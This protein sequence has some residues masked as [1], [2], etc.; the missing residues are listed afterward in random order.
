MPCSV[1]C[2]S[3]SASRRLAQG[4]SSAIIGRHVSTPNDL[5]R[6]DANLVG[7]DI[8]GGTAQLHQQL[9]FR[10]VSGLARA[11]TPIKGLYLASA[12]AHPGG[13]VHGACG[14]NAARAALLHAPVRRVVR[15]LAWRADRLVP[16]APR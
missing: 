12:S 9:V 11:E 6:L 3:G 8:S 16:L 5:E 1:G 2:W 14:A 4:F 10:P 7:G 15:R 13:A